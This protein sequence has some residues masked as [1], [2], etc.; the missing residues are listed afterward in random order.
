[1][2]LDD[3]KQI[4]LGFS[5]HLDTHFW[6]LSMFHMTSFYFLQTW[7]IPGTFVFNLLGGSLFGVTRGFI[8]CVLMNA[9]GAYS[10]FL[11]SRVFGA[12]LVK[13]DFIKGKMEKMKVLVDENKDNLFWYMT[14]LRLFPGSPNWVMN[15]S[16][17][18]FGVPD[19]YVFFSVFFGLMPWNLLTV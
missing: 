13:R 3:A 16:F 10:C 2:N 7:C 8:Y 6:L 17:P 9:I 14:F 18:H 12:N 1:M 4:T 15:I 19:V 11:W 5:K